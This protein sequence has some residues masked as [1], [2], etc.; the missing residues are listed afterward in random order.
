MKMHRPVRAITVRQALSRSDGSD[1]QA[2]DNYLRE[3]HAYNEQMAR[4]NDQEEPESGR[5]SFASH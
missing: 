4:Y 3:M 2:Y 5:C 1:A